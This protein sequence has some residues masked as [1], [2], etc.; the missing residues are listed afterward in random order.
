MERGNIVKWHVKQGDEVKA[1]DSLADIETD[2]ATLI[3]ENQDEGFIAKLLVPDGS[4]DVPVGT[5]V[6]I[7]VEDQSHVASFASFTIAAPSSSSASPTPAAA[8]LQ[9][10]SLHRTPMIS[11]PLR[12]TPDGLRISEQPHGP[13]STKPTTQSVLPPSRP[14]T[15]ATKP[16]S[17]T[18]PASSVSSSSYT[19]TPNSQIRKVI[20]SRLVESKVTIPALYFTTEVSL[21]EVTK[22]RASLLDQGIKV[23]LND[24]VL[25]SLARA[26]SLVPEANVF[27][28]YKKNQVLPFSSVD[29]SVA[30]A[31]D[32]GLITP[33]VKGADKKSLSQISRDV[34]DLA[35]R[36]VSTALM[37]TSHD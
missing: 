27:W 9:P 14:P 16:P 20:A 32:K 10:P 24:I 26:L 29:I 11:F 3:F 17:S 30:V 19:D 23:S 31:T 35:S 5:P 37:I 22:F 12:M 28:D 1:G 13:V 21:N 18:T 15:P 6:A 25:K 8:V 33:I 2:K 4:K 36:A 34:K 7:V